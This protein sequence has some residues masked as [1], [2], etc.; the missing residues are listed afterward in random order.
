MIFLKKIKKNNINIINKIKISFNDSNESERKII[1]MINLEDKI[2][3]MSK[4]E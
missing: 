1:D 2:D 3:N 4:N